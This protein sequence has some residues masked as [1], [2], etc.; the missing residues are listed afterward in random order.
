[1]TSSISKKNY[2]IYFYKRIVFYVLSQNENR[3]DE[4]VFA[5]TKIEK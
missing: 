4:K 3:L 2:V 5:K 1:M